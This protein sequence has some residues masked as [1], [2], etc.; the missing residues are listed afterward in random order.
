MPSQRIRIGDEYYLLASALAPRRP[1]LLLNHAD[2]FAIFDVAGDVPL[3]GLDPFGLF[4]EGTRFLDRFE[5][6]LNGEFPVLLSSTASDDGSELVTHLSNTDERRDGEI[7]LQRDTVA[8]ERSKTLFQGELHERLRLRNYGQELLRLELAVMFGA[9]FADVFELRGID[10]PRR[11]DAFPPRVEGEAV[12]LRYRGLDGVER[13][14]EITFSGSAW[15]LAPAEAKVA[16]AL[17]PGEETEAE[18]RVRCTVG[19]AAPPPARKYASTLAGVRS[20]RRSW[21]EALPALY[22]NNEGFNDWLNCSQADLAILRTLG[23][24]GRSVVYAG[25]P[26][27]AT[28][29]GR[30]GLITAIETLAFAPELAAGTL[31]TLASLQGREVNAERD[32]EP[33]KILHEMR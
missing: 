4:H 18:I 15:A 21:T 2:S 19:G 32:E 12:R 17:G 26:W 6:R 14:T 10:R 13:Q 16:V 23:D 20:E 8:L 31:R 27:F 3:A 5:L 30:D 22:S 1:Q 11:G 9:D 29:F 25:I 7:V 24:E 33:G 28:V